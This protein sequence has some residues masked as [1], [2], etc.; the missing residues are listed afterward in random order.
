CRCIITPPAGVF[1]PVP[2]EPPPPPPHPPQPPQPP[3]PQGGRGVLVQPAPP[4]PLQTPQPEPP[5]PPPQPPRPESLQNVRV[6]LTITDQRGGTAP[7]KKAITI[8][9][10]DG[11]TNRV[12]SGSQF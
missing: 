9:A 12:R 8:V 5:S 10:G 4:R 1:F 11:M 3:Q 6:E 7:V 2:P